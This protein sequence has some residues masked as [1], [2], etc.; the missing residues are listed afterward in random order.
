MLPI[1]T[2][3]IDNNQ[4]SLF[5]W[6]RRSIAQVAES[7]HIAK[8]RRF[9]IRL[10]DHIKGAVYEAVP[11]KYVNAYSIVKEGYKTGRSLYTFFSIGSQIHATGLKEETQ[12]ALTEKLNEFLGNCTARASHKLAESSGM[13]YIHRKM[14]LSLIEQ[15]FSRLPPDL[16]SQLTPEHIDQI[17]KSE[18]ASV[19]FTIVRSEGA[20]LVKKHQEALISSFTKKIVRLLPAGQAFLQDLGVNGNEFESILLQVDKIDPTHCKVKLYSSSRGETATTLDGRARVGSRYKFMSVPND[21]LTGLG[22]FMA[23]MQGKGTGQIRVRAEDIKDVLSEYFGVPAEAGTLYYQ[24]NGMFADNL[25]LGNIRHKMIYEEFIGA[26]QEGDAILLSLQIAELATAFTGS[27]TDFDLAAC[28]DLSDQVSSLQNQVSS[29]S[30]YSLKQAHL[31]TL[32]DLTSRLQRRVA[33]T[34]RCREEQPARP[35]TVVPPLLWPLFNAAFS[36]FGTGSVFMKRFGEG[37]QRALGRDYSLLL[38]AARQEYLQHTSPSHEK[39]LSSAER[40]AA[41]FMCGFV[42]YALCNLLLAGIA[43]AIPASMAV[44]PL[45]ALGL[46]AFGTNEINMLIP[47]R[48]SQAYAEMFHEVLFFLLPYLLEWGYRLFVSEEIKRNVN[49]WIRTMD[50]MSFRATFREEQM[51]KAQAWLECAEGDLP[52][53]AEEIIKKLQADNLEFLNLAA[54]EPESLPK[55]EADE[56][57]YPL[58]WVGRLNSPAGAAL[59]INNA[60]LKEINEKTGLRMDIWRQLMLSNSNLFGCAEE[61]KESLAAFFAA[62]GSINEIESSLL[63]EEE[64]SLY[65]GRIL[66]PSEQNSLFHRAVQSVMPAVGIGVAAVA[67]GTVAVA[68]GAAYAIGSLVN[69]KK[70]KTSAIL[71]AAMKELEAEQKKP[72]EIKELQAAAEVE[73]PS[74]AAAILSEPSANLD[75]LPDLIRPGISSFFLPDECYCT[76]HGFIHPAHVK[77]TRTSLAEMKKAHLLICRLGEEFEKSRPQSAQELF[78]Y[79]ASVKKSYRHQMRILYAL[80]PGDKESSLFLSLT[81]DRI[82]RNLSCALSSVEL[83]SRQ[84][85]S[86]LF[87][88][89]EWTE[90]QIIRFSHEAGEIGFAFAA[91]DINKIVKEQKEALT[92]GVVDAEVLQFI[93]HLDRMPPDNSAGLIHQ[94]AF[95][96]AAEKLMQRNTAKY[97]PMGFAEYFLARF[98][99]EGSSVSFSPE[100]KRVYQ[101]LA[102]MQ[103]GPS[104]GGWFVPA[105]NRNCYDYPFA[106]MTAF[107]EKLSDMHGSPDILA[108]LAKEV[109]HFCLQYEDAARQLP[110]SVIDRIIHG[111]WHSKYLWEFTPE[112]L[113]AMRLYLIAKLAYQQ[114]HSYTPA[115]LRRDAAIARCIEWLENRESL[116]PPAQA[117]LAANFR[118]VW[119][120]NL[121]LEEPAKLQMLVSSDDLADNEDQR[122]FKIDHQQNTVGQLRSALSN[123]LN[124]MERGDKDDAYYEKF[125]LKYLLRD[126]DSVH[127]LLKTDSK[128]LARAWKIFNKDETKVDLEATQEFYLWLQ[129]LVRHYSPDLKPGKFGFNDQG[130]KGRVLR[131][132]QWSTFSVGELDE[133]ERLSASLDCFLSQQTSSVPLANDLP[134][135]RRFYPLYCHLQKDPAFLRMAAQRMNSSIWLDYYALQEV[136]GP[137]L[138]FIKKDG[139]GEE[140]SLNLKDGSTIFKRPPPP[141]VVIVAEDGSKEIV[142]IKYKMVDGEKYLDLALASLEEGLRVSINF[143]RAAPRARVYRNGLCIKTLDLPEGTTEGSICGG[144]LTS[145]EPCLWLREESAAKLHPVLQ[146]LARTCHVLTYQSRGSRLI[147]L[148]KENEEPL[149]FE[150]KEG[151]TICLTHGGMRIAKTQYLP[152]ASMLGP[153]LM[154]E[155]NGKKEVLFERRPLLSYGLG[156]LADSVQGDLSASFDSLI[157]LSPALAQLLNPI[158][159]SK[160]KMGFTVMPVSQDGELAFATVDDAALCLFASFGRDEAKFKEYLRKFTQ[161][162]E[163]NENLPGSVSSVD[164]CIAICALQIAKNSI[165]TLGD[166]LRLGLAFLQNAQMQKEK[167]DFRKKL[168][169]LMELF[170]LYSDYLSL[171]LHKSLPIEEGDE[172]IFLTELLTTLE[173]IAGG[174]AAR[175]RRY[176]L[177]PWG[178]VSSLFKNGLSAL[179]MPIFSGDF[180][181]RLQY[182]DGIYIHPGSRSLMEILAGFTKS[183][184]AGSNQGANILKSLDE[185]LFLPQP[186]LTEMGKNVAG[187]VVKAIAINRVGNHL[188]W[189]DPRYTNNKPETVIDEW[190]CKIVHEHFY[191]LTALLSYSELS[192]EERNYYFSKVSLKNREAEKARVEEWLSKLVVPQKHAYLPLV[193]LKKIARMQNEGNSLDMKSAVAKAYKDARWDCGTFFSSAATWLS[194]QYDYAMENYANKKS[195]IKGVGKLAKDALMRGNLLPLSFNAVGAAMGAS[196]YFI[197]PQARTQREIGGQYDCMPA[198]IGANEALSAGFFALA[199]KY[200]TVQET[201]PDAP[202]QLPLAMPSDPEKGDY[203]KERICDSVAEYGRL[204]SNKTLFVLREGVSRQQMEADICAFSAAFQREKEELKSSILK[205]AGKHASCK[206]TMDDLFNMLLEP[207]FKAQL[208]KKGRLTESGSALVYGRVAQLALLESYQVKLNLLQSAFKNR[209]DNAEVAKIMV[210]EKHYK[211]GIESNE[212]YLM[213]CMLFE[214]KSN[215]WLRRLQAEQMQAALSYDK[216]S[217]VVEMVPGSGKT[218]FGVI[219]NLF[220]CWKP[221]R[222]PIAVFTKE[223]ITSTKK[224]VA[225]RFYRFT[226]RK[227]VYMAIDRNTENLGSLRHLLLRI[228]KATECGDVLI[229]T[230]EDLQGLELLFAE[231]ILSLDG[232]AE[233]SE[234]Y[235]QVKEKFG[236]LQK[237]LA[238]VRSA[239]RI[240]DE[241]HEILRPDEVEKY[242]IGEESE[243]DQKEILGAELVSRLFSESV[244]AGNLKIE[245]VLKDRDHLSDEIASLPTRVAAHPMF[246]FSPSEVMD[247]ADYLRD[248]AVGEPLWLLEHKYRETV[249][250]ARGMILTLLPNMAGECV[251]VAYGLSKA[252]GNKEFAIPYAGNNAPL[253]EAIFESPHETLAK[254]YLY[255]LQKGLT[256]DQAEKFIEKVKVMIKKEMETFHVEEAETSIMHFMHKHIGEKRLTAFTRE[257]VM[258]NPAAILFYVTY[259]VAPT[260]TYYGKSI[261]STSSNFAS[262]TDYTH[263]YSGTIYNRLFYPERTKY[264]RQPDTTGE[265]LHALQ[266]SQTEGVVTALPEMGKEGV[267]KA[268]ISGLVQ[269]PNCMMAIDAGALFNGVQNEAVAREIRAAL[270]D[271]RPEIKAVCYFGEDNTLKAIVD[272]S[273]LPVSIS[274]RSFKEEERLCYLDERHTFGVDIHQKRE[275]SAHITIGRNFFS[276][277]EQAIWRQRG[278]ETLGQTVRFMLMPEAK[279]DM[280]SAG[281][282]ISFE[283]MLHYLVSM[284]YDSL[285]THSLQSALQKQQDVLRSFVMKKLLSCDVKQAKKLGREYRDLFVQETEQTASLVFSAARTQQSTRRYIAKQQLK[286]QGIIEKSTV[287]SSAEKAQ[288]L[289]RIA[290][291]D[292][293]LLPE[294]TLL[295]AGKEVSRVYGARVK[296]RTKV[297][298][299]EQERQKEQQRLQERTSC[300][301]PWKFNC[302]P[303]PRHM[304]WRSDLSLLELGWMQD[305]TGLKNK[306]KITNGM[307]CMRLRDLLKESKN[308]DLGCFAE[309][310]NEKMFATDNLL[311]FRQHYDFAAAQDKCFIGERYRSW[312]ATVNK[313]LVVYDKKQKKYFTLGLSLADTRFWEKKLLAGNSNE[314]YSYALCNVFDGALENPA[315]IDP[316]LRCLAD[317]EDFKDTMLRWK[318]FNCEKRYNYRENQ[319]FL[320][321]V[322]DALAKNPQLS[323]GTL[324]RAVKNTAQIRLRGRD[325]TESPLAE[326]VLSAEVGHCSSTYLI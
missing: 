61:R 79:L 114:Q 165:T 160:E 193:A 266:G 26:P 290:D 140:V 116:L 159:L 48:Y 319:S 260:I 167:P 178:A 148:Q 264:C 119:G 201:A 18:Y 206:M 283:G 316:K 8:V 154:L 270:K 142:A 317:E 219:L 38:E 225:E 92:P 74:P 287:F 295:E 145:H 180:A 261:E 173:E 60:A 256:Y 186:S 25:L 67:V 213:G 55:E 248:N 31:D 226:G 71:I 86:G 223:L 254:T 286:W 294:K 14:T 325:V 6:G 157:N 49:D 19:I 10:F 291:I 62:H 59:P 5:R 11:K 23:T 106:I 302:M 233:T 96:L 17:F 313:A 158:K 182:L 240:A 124:E 91:A 64:S 297:K 197:A 232:A 247:V 115:F 162:I 20:S 50:A 196:D 105:P 13:Q 231:T 242:P 29:M 22:D 110:E 82:K 70:E 227:T 268:F 103:E 143:S 265:T 75:K 80:S 309:L 2:A 131:M 51:E 120:S 42:H 246:G 163:L 135:L 127:R 262:M 12:V 269:D 100:E 66:L 81:A 168:I 203:F 210:E 141:K 277:V 222:L 183:C 151:E 259:A 310:M 282:E 76:E 73:S 324:F 102:S 190:D 322:E 78:D 224:E 95:Y 129:R 149:L 251:D 209:A 47:E 187:E 188:G 130:E 179:F 192:T 123:L 164:L 252:D 288:M 216:G 99:H 250:M 245:E 273:G 275:A 320:A 144:L 58:S 133:N 238:L 156:N 83:F 108:D 32:H 153:Y 241:C 211:I 204:H 253:E 136:N 184:L 128:L 237:I 85:L 44:P 257:D 132:R 305:C 45:V 212:R 68:G 125:I 46:A 84:K 63:P 229:T 171:G 54:A 235:F 292:P 255:Y 43:A 89:K 147:V 230:K 284:E 40:A 57:Q 65:S 312:M 189:G 174:A 279:K 243:L 30:Y 194:C 177:D 221:G 16:V 239:H 191:Y 146:S 200:F 181:K 202:W 323:I 299:K 166:V 169:L 4:F 321:L 122:L 280:E 293:Q 176:G 107:L 170:K 303:T 109:C 36:V 296:Q 15:V 161:A 172:A 118:E 126:L 1:M 278:L 24:D 139:S 228:E 111:K 236:Y 113:Q 249:A 3:N 112:D 308:R 134:T 104:S 289:A 34:L 234:R 93:L 7:L 205:M 72:F 52:A 315:S 88:G 21:K 318:I 121:S 97:Q 27:A 41:V 304:G 77:D 217:V 199:T 185:K 215:M 39:P 276:K 101:A 198:L 94:S 90:E 175:L 220:H 314:N 274:A 138:R 300:K 267:Q 306:D 35:E 37:L 195:V 272:P 207:D 285:K 258:H 28:L 9:G 263:Y 98:W 117:P 69:A 208:Q 281:C 301:T 56:D 298:E 137:C 244:K 311:G 218:A 150:E 307:P 87:D 271:K 152:H 155:G 214:A 33:V 326:L 53:P